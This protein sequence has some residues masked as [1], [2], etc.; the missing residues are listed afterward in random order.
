[1]SAT[2]TRKPLPTVTAERHPSCP[3]FGESFEEFEDPGAAEHF[4]QQAA[5]KGL[6][7][8]R[9]YTG[10]CIYGATRVFYRGTESE[11]PA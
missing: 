1:M 4:A 5:E 7:V 6:Q 8:T 9:T 2:F 11:V 3:D 10:P